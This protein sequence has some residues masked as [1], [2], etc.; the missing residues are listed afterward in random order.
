MTGYAV[1]VLSCTATRNASAD[2]QRHRKMKKL[3]KFWLIIAINIYLNGVVL[4]SIIKEII[5]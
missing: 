3:T 2:Q 4:S 5:S 1:N